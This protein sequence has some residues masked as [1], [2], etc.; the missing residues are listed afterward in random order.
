MG[1]LQ[2]QILPGTTDF[3]D[4]K[5]EQRG[6]CMHAYNAPAGARDYP[7]RKR[8]RNFMVGILNGELSD[9]VALSW[10]E[11]K[12]KRSTHEVRLRESCGFES[13]PIH[14]FLFF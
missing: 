5:V 10:R 3:V 8:N 11:R 2:V 12:G 13:R 7:A 1:G 9:R 4:R 14:L 6:V